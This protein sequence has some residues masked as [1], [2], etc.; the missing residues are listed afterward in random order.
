MWQP[1]YDWNWEGVFID[2]KSRTSVKKSMQLSAKSLI[3]LALYLLSCELLISC[4][5]ESI[6]AD[7]RVG[8]HDFTT[9][10]LK[11]SLKNSVCK[12]SWSPPVEGR[13]ITCCPFDGV[14]LNFVIEDLL[15]RGGGPPDLD[16]LQPIMIYYEL[17]FW[18]GNG[19]V[20]FFIFA[21]SLKID[22]LVLLKFSS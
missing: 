7:C 8:F 6:F 9:N 3:S 1:R 11:L 16:T 14:V 22:S 20:K 15:V 13:E 2:L 18:T 19:I 5:P 21:I 4:F 12:I 17:C 10:F